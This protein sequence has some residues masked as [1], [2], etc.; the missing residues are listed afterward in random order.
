[1]TFKD[2]VEKIQP[3][4]L[5]LG[6]MSKKRLRANLYKATHSCEGTGRKRIK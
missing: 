5:R 2:L 1:M 4:K 3:R 6:K